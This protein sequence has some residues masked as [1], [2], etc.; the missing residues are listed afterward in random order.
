MSIIFKIDLLIKICFV[1]ICRIPFNTSNTYEGRLRYSFV[2]VVHLEVDIDYLDEE[3]E[4]SAELNIDLP[5]RK[6][7]PLSRILE[8]KGNISIVMYNRIPQCYEFTMNALLKNI[9]YMHSYKYVPSPIYTPFSYNQ[10]SLL[11][12]ARS[13]FNQKHDR[14]IYERHLYFFD[15]YK[16]QFQ[17]HPIWIN[18]VRDPIYR[19][20]AE[21]NRSREVCLKTDRCFVQPDTI[22]ETLDDCVINRS[23]QE[24]I[25][26]FNGVSRMLPFFCGLTN[27]FRCQEENKWALQQAKENIDFFYTVVGFAEEYYKFLFVLGM[28]FCFNLK[29]KSKS[30]DRHFSSI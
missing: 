1:C 25:S 8:V 30:A 7:H 28:F 9:S 21:Y 11:S 3:Y 12:I 16:L 5:S 18:L 6:S 13:L 17:S 24:C 2:D 26:P 10:S 19:V 23:P 15:F 22:N 14:L 20:A 27:P 29:R 4:P